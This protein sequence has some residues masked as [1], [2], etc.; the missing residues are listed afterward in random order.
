MLLLFG[1]VMFRGRSFF[2]PFSDPTAG[3]YLHIG[4][5]WLHGQIPYTTT[6]DYRPP[7]FFALYAAAIA[8]FGAAFARDGLA[9]LSLAATTLAVGLTTARLDAAARSNVGWW[10]AAF[11]VMLTPV[12]DGIAGVAEL[13]ISAFVAWA[14]YFAIA[15]PTR[16]R[17]ALFSGLLCG[18]AL[19]CKFTAVPLVAIPIALLALHS[20][21]AL[22]TLVVFFTAFITPLIADVAL[23]AAAHRLDALW[24]ANVEATLRRGASASH[25]EL[26]ARNRI[27]V[28]R[29]LGAFAPQIEFA[30][31]GLSANVNRSRI[32]SAGWAIAALLS[33]VAAGEFYERQFVLLSA[34]VAILGAIGFTHVSSLVRSARW[35][36]ALVI[37]TV[38]LT[39]GLHDYFETNQTI[40]FFVHRI[41][42]GRH[43]WRPDQFDE[44]RSAMACASKGPGQL[45]L[46]EQNPYLY[47]VLGDPS[48]TVY[49]YSDHLLDPRLSLMAGIDGRAELQRVLH[50]H[51]RYIVVSHLDDYRY[52]PDR[53]RFVKAILARSYTRA[54]GGARFSVYRYDGNANAGSADARVP[55]AAATS[56]RG[57]SRTLA[58]RI[59]S[60][61]GS[62]PN[63]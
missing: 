13:Q 56:G 40:A 36:R 59:S 50:A 35:S 48:P 12:D 25:N 18:L 10:A 27:N 24:N 47:D 20:R 19:Q 51:P 49:A 15:Y 46:L 16:L 63:A 57:R 1:I 4:L 31:L 45:F 23:Y 38:L 6:W 33:T 2:T 9:L 32:A 22:R 42:L 62:S 37:A 58:G 17:A 41:V 60:S 55:C 5:A 7:G 14:I 44:V 21:A 52:A 26:F 54:F 28:V 39:F 29:Q 43:E 8:L 53:V 34:P 11:F 30:L 61:G 3:L